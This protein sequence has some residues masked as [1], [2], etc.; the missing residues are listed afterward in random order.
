MRYVLKHAGMVSDQVRHAWVGAWTACRKLG[1]RSTC[2]VLEYK[3]QWIRDE[4]K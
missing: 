2:S 3:V 4:S 1:V